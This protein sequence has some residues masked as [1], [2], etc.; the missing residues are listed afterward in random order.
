[1]AHVALY[2]HVNLD[3]IYRLREMPRP[4]TTVEVAESH[5]HY[6]GTAGN[7]AAVAGKLGAPVKLASFVGT[8]FPSDYREHLERHGVDLTEV[9]TKPGYTTPTY[10]A[11]TDPDGNALGV[12]D[13]GPM[14]DL[15]NFELL[16]GALD[17]AAIVHFATGRPAYYERVAAEARRRDLPILLDPGQELRALYD[18]GHLERL[19]EAADLFLVNEHERDEALQK[20]S[21]GAI[22]QLFDHRLEAILV[23]HGK[24]GCTLHLDGETIHVP[25]VPVSPEK[26]VDPTGAGDAFRGAFHA[27]RHH[28]RDLPSAC[29]WGNAAASIAIQHA[30]GQT[31][32]P[33]R[34]I[35][36]ALA[37][38]LAPRGTGA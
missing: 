37:E 34:S 24:E 11:F 12:I 28:G 32:L 30:G 19:L 21:Y 25:A 7:I 16:T 22:E 36:E 33:S 2:G 9:V 15:L 6:G 1:M 31:H 26:I 29:C 8:D 4:N 17:G 35:I 38:T 3:R 14:R 10:W 13:Q 23:T 20:M 18:P 27:A 5:V